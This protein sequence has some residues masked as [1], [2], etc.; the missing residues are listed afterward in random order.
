[1]ANKLFTALKEDTNDARKK[2][3]IVVGVSIAVIGGAVLLSKMKD[4][5]VD[6]L[7]LTEGAVDAIADATTE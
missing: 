7:V 1:M 4:N 6:V 3:V 2:A 5:T